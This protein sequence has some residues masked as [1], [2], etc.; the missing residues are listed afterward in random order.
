MFGG[1]GATPCTGGGITS[2]TS[3]DCSPPRNGPARH[4]VG[5]LALDRSKTEVPVATSGPQWG[6]R[7]LRR[8]RPAGG[9]HPVAP[10]PRIF[11]VVGHVGT[12]PARVGRR[13]P[14][15]DLGHPRARPECV[16]GGPRPVLR[17][18]LGGR[19]GRSSRCLWVRASRGGRVVSGWLPVAGVLAR[20]PRTRERPVVVRHRTGLQERRGP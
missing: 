13:P 6:G 11:G 17:G 19:H 1:S 18:R 14:G 7:V 4:A 16:A 15:G 3:S 10:Q 2:T 5:C 20:P 12:E 9:S 8:T